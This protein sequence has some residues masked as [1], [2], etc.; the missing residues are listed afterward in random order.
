LERLKGRYA[1]RGAVRDGLNQMLRILTSNLGTI[2]TRIKTLCGDD[3]ARDVHSII[4][5]ALKDSWESIKEI[6]F[7]SIPDEEYDK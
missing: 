7:G 4:Q 5:Q 2:P 6:E 3:I 1:E